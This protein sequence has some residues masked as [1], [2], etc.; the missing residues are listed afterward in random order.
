[1]S[2]LYMELMEMNFCPRV[3][4]VFIVM[5]TVRLHDKCVIVLPFLK[6]HLSIFFFP[7]KLVIQ[8][9]LGPSIVHS[10]EWEP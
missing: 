8:K 3:F 6:F 4:K 9:K 5:T 2:T 7:F 1:M 10:F